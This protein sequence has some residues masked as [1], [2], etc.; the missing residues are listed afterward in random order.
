[1]EYNRNNRFYNAMCERVGE[2]FSEWL[3]RK[4]WDEELDSREMAGIAYGKTKNG[5]NITGWMEK[6]GIPRR[7]R[8]DA[9]ALQWKDNPE[10][11]KKQSEFASEN[12]SSGTT[13]RKSLIKVMQSEEYKKKQRVSKTGKKN[14]M[15]GVSGVIHPR[16]KRHLTNDERTHTRNL[17]KIRSWRTEV[18]ERDSYECKSCGYNKGGILVA[19]HLNGYNWDKENRTNV[20]NGITL[21]KHCHLEF[22][23]EYGYG[24][25]TKEQFEE[26][27]Q[28]LA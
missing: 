25:N 5:P 17:Y 18:F 15:Y 8:S 12:L 20:D 19:H 28:A 11:R 14:G 4:Y 26:Y 16:W 7:K 21:C 2:D 3:E 13:A 1:M 23:S 10:R 9:I 27:N 24:D 6:L 22:H